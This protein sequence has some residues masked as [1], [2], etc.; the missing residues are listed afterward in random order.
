M[1]FIKNT[2]VNI[3]NEAVRNVIKRS[4]HVLRG[5]C[6]S[7]TTEQIVLISVALVL[8]TILLA[9]KDQIKGFLTKAG[10]TVNALKVN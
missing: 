4:S 8:A 1:I 10:N 5:E 6:G 9:F 2:Y 7:L 3:K